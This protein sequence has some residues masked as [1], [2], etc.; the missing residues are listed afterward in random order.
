M[1]RCETRACSA[2]LALAGD[3]AQRGGMRLF[4]TYE[5][6]WHAELGSATSGDLTH[7]RRLLVVACIVSG[8]SAQA[9]LLRQAGTHCTAIH[10]MPPPQSFQ[11]RAPP[12]L[13]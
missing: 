10:R 2:V 1:L 11:P 3:A 5:E 9:A 8:R 6:E 4:T 12:S 7:H 13:V